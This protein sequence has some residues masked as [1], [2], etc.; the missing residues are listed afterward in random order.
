[1]AYSSTNAILGGS[2]QKKIQ[3]AAALAAAQAAKRAAQEAKRAARRAA[4]PHKQKTYHARTA[5]QRYA[6]GEKAT[7]PTIETIKLAWPTFTEQQRAALGPKIIK[8]VESEYHGEYGSTKY[9]PK[10]LAEYAPGKFNKQLKAVG[11]ARADAEMQ[12]KTDEAF[13]DDMGRAIDAGLL[14]VHGGALVKVAKAGSTALKA[15]RAAQ[16]L[17]AVEGGKAVSAGAKAAVTGTKAAGKVATVAEKAATKTRAARTAAASTRTAKAA[18][19]AGGTRAGK[20]A[21]KTAKGLKTGYRY[22]P[23]RPRNLPKYVIGAEGLAGISAVPAAI[24]AGDASKISDALL[25]G[26]SL[27]KKGIHI[28]GKE[29]DNLG[30]VGNVVGDVPSKVRKDLNLGCF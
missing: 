7:R 23:V 2:E 14:V 9:L 19:V 12:V 15:R 25:G 24:Q 28:A 30:V 26:P 16:A 5:V 4:H 22:S 18:R 8:R 10:F 27:F 11:S 1:M 13:A 17:K 29:L 20:A 6:S 21:A 3:A